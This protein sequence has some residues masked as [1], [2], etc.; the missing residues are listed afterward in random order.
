MTENIDNKERV[1]GLNA[2]C[3]RLVTKRILG[4]IRIECDMADQDWIDA[5][6]VKLLADEWEIIHFGCPKLNEMQ[7]SKRIVLIAVRERPNELLA[8]ILSELRAIRDELRTLNERIA[9]TSQENI[10][11]AKKQVESM[12]AIIPEQFRGMFDTMLK[13]E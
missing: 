2:N 13:R 9:V 11:T 3:G 6:M 10:E 7:Y 4:E 1:D 12:R 8:E 5:Q